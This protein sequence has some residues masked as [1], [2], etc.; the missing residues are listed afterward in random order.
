MTSL[1]NIF[2]VCVCIDSGSA[3]I[4]PEDLDEYSFC[5]LKERVSRDV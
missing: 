2:T 5:L 4:W 1:V 3:F